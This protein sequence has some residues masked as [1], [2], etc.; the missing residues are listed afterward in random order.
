M[1]SQSCPT[2]IFF[3][4]SATRAISVL[5]H[6]T[7]ALELL[8]VSCGID[9]KLCGFQDKAHALQFGESTQSGYF[10]ILRLSLPAVTCS[11]LAARGLLTGTSNHP[12]A[13]Q[14]VWMLS[15]PIHEQPAVLSS[16]TLSIDEVAEVPTR[17]RPMPA[18]PFGPCGFGC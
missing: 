4:L 15:V 12:V 8:A 11:S 1:Y 13:G 10:A 7:E 2:N 14:P 9:G 3:A 18:E 16:A 5:R 6:K 17:S